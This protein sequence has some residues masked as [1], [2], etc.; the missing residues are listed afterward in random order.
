MSKLSKRGHGEGTVYDHV[1][2][3]LSAHALHKECSSTSGAAFWH[4][5]RIV[6]EIGLDYLGVGANRMA[7][8]SC[9]AGIL[10][11]TRGSQRER[12]ARR[13]PRGAPRGRQLAA[14]TA[15]EVIDGLAR[16]AGVAR[17]PGR[18][19]KQARGRR[20]WSSAPPMSRTSIWP[21][22]CFPG[23]GTSPRPASSTSA[24]SRTSRQAGRAELSRA[25]EGVRAVNFV[26]R[27]K[28]PG[29][30]PRRL[31]RSLRVRLYTLLW[32]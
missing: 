14:I 30:S 31:R 13:A 16:P 29:T 18:P 21:P 10:H 32:R 23:V 20:R 1:V 27:R 8:R 7:W 4:R 12:C 26:V 11:R 19:G 6:R 2:R 24:T 5:R 17:R 3:L 9:Q 22:S 15:L 25:A 28:R